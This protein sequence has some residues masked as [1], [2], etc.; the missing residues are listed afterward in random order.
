MTDKQ[1]LHA[2][3]DRLPETE[4]EA[5]ARYLQ[6]LISQEELPLEPAMLDRID[7]ARKNSG[8][9]I[10]HEEILHEFGL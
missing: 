5:A 4:S 9:G 3:V 10:S 2:L 1:Q 7:A 8:P 6:F